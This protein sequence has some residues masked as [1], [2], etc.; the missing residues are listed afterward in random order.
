MLLNIRELYAVKCFLPATFMLSSLEAQNI[1][2]YQQ[3]DFYFI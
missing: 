3:V 1:Q 2:F